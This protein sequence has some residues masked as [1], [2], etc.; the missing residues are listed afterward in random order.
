[1]T[2][3]KSAKTY[4]LKSNKGQIDEGQCQTMV[5]TL[6]GSAAGFVDGTGTAAQFRYP[7][8]VTLDGSGNLYVADASNYRVR[9]VTLDGAVTTFVGSTSGSANGTGA[10]AQFNYPRAAAIDGSGNLYISDINNHRIRKVSPDG[11]VTT[12][13]GSTAGFANGTGTAARFNYPRGIAMDGSGVLYVSDATNNRIRSVSPDGVVS[14]IAG[15][16]TAG[17]TDGLATSARFNTPGGLALDGSGTIYVADTN[18]HR[19]RKIEL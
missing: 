3:P 6:A 14:T 4:R 8:A 5:S 16:S 17:S 11:V 1:M 18:N 13:A 7:Y 12:L 10:A 2:N 9:K 19:I 15:V